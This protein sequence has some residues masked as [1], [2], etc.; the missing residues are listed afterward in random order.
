MNRRPL[1]GSLSINPHWSQHAGC[2]KPNL[3]LR[4]TQ[5]LKFPV[6][7]SSVDPRDKGVLLSVGAIR[8]LITGSDIC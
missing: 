4:L 5:A 8:L 3:R 7:S 6:K 1:R 2:A